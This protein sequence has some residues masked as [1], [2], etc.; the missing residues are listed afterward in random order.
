MKL[1]TMSEAAS[2]QNS[3]GQP[4]LA[5]QLHLLDVLIILSKR[6]RFILWFTLGAA[7]LTAVTVLLIP[8]KYTAEAVVLPPSQNSSISSALLSQVAGSG[9]LASLAGAGLGL[10]NPGD[11]YVSLFRSRTVEDAMIQRFNLMARYRH[12]TMV[13]TRIAFEKHSTVVLGVKDGLIRITVTDRDPKFAAQLANAYVAEFRKHSD[14]LTLT[15]ASQRRAFFQQQL[16]EA[17]GNLTKAENAMKTTERSTGVLQLDSQARALI[18]SAAVLRGQI[19]AKEVQLQSMRSAVTEDNPQ[20]VMAEQQLDALKAQ[21][22]K[23]AGPSGNVT[24]DISL[25]KTNIP[26]AGMTYLN[27]LR[28]LRYYETIDELLAKQFEMAK[29]DEAHQGV[30]QISDVAI[31]PDKKS[32][33]HRALLVI[34]TILLSFFVASGW[35]LVANAFQ[36]MRNNPDE[37]RRLDAL[38]ATFR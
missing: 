13:D 2:R 24:G 7:V 36:R 5:Q 31:P 27:A 9:A 22:A 29:L 35:S 4:E 37:R 18:E 19:A 12:K 30:I 38:R 3:D 15:E 10:K 34:L 14:S 26:E 8:N 32:S 11:M 21:L 28:D 25:S 6:R 1:E 17:D 20:Y 16:L 23:V 33:P